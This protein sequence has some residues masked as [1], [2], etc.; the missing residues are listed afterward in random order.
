L[1]TGNTSNYYDDDSVSPGVTH[2]MND[3]LFDLKYASA[4]VFGCGRGVVR[5]G[6]DDGDRYDG[7]C[8]DDRSGEGV[9]AVSSA[10]LLEQN[11][12]I[13]LPPKCAIERNE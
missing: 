8:G 4:R 7:P 2:L 11:Q 3:V 12:R 5:G 9:A 1:H 13:G 6:D 10:L